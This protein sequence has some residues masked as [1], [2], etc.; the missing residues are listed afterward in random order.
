MLSDGSEI[1][2]DNWDPRIELENV[3]E[4][5]QPWTS[6]RRAFMSTIVEQDADGN[7]KE[8]RIKNIQYKYS[9][10]GSFVEKFQVE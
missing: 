1:S 6:H 7:N 4:L 8:V 3:I 10:L 5:K 2:A 9:N